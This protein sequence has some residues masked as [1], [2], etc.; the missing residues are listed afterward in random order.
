MP[1]IN[2]SDRQA[3]HSQTQRARLPKSTRSMR[4]RPLDGSQRSQ[5][6]WGNWWGIN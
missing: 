6:I 4:P 3:Q 5:R 2:S 1:G